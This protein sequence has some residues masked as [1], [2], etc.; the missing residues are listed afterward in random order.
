MKKTHTASVH[1]FKKML[2][3]REM[4]QIKGG[5][6]PSTNL[7]GDITKE[8]SCYIYYKGERFKGECGLI[9]GRCKCYTSIGDYQT[10]DD[11]Y[12]CEDALPS[13]MLQS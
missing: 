10:P 9:N 12:G 11:H 8:H 1:F 13:T 7:C 6:T 3:K 2:T 5:S 4:K